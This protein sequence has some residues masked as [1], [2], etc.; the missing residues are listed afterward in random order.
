MTMK[1][2]SLIKT[3]GGKFYLSKY[4]IE[5]FPPNYTQLTYGEPFA[6]GANT[7]L[8]KEPSTVEFLNELHYPTYLIHKI[9]L[10]QPDRLFDRLKNIPYEEWLFTSYQT[11]NG[12]L[13]EVSVAEREIILRRFSRGG[14]KK[15]FAWSDRLRGGRPG[16][17]NAWIN[18]LA[19][20]PLLK[21]RYQASNLTITNEDAITLMQRL[22]A[23][24]VFFY[25]DPPYLHETR[26]STKAYD[27]EM[28]DQQHAELLDFCVQ[29]QSKILI[30]GYLSTLYRKKLKCWNQHRKTVKNNSGQNSIKQQR[31]EI[32]WSNY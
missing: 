13:D 5:L 30:S 4:L 14:L 19:S 24:G 31:T 20:F 29:A 1:K 28:T 10:E 16:D 15:T 25:C 18:F 26:K 27:L 8:Q 11:M 2:L 6:G 21:Q 7:W 3:H 23:N 12:G 32:M 9:M 22:D 17:E